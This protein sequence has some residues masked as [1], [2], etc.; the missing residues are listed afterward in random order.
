MGATPYLLVY[1][2][3]VVFF[4]IGILVRFNLRFFS[5][6][7]VLLK[8]TSKNRIFYISCGSIQEWA[9]N[10]Q[11][12]YMHW[13]NTLV[14]AFTRAPNKSVHLMHVHCQFFSLEP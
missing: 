13:L 8:K 6:S 11:I 4:K 14:Y 7:E 10:N 5:R 3:R 9:V 2:H 12:R 1:S